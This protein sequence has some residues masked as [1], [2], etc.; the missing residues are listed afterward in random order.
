MGLVICR[1]SREARIPR[2][3]EGQHQNPQH[4]LENPQ[5]QRPHRGLHTG[6][7][8]N[9]PVRQTG[10][11]VEILLQQGV[12]EMFSPVQSPPPAPAGSPPGPRG[13]PWWRGLPH[14]HRA[15]CRRCPP[16][17]GAGWSADRSGR[18]VRS[19]P[20]RASH[21]PAPPGAA[22]RP[23]PHTGRPSPPR[24]ARCTGSSPPAPLG[25]SCGKFSPS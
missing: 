8:Q 6:N 3:D 16:R 17:S 11:I 12:G 22:D 7:P 15:R 9:R 24:K 4:R 20:C 25:S 13:S 10:G 23:P 14:C 5:N 21:R 19:P 1:D 18:P 2:Q